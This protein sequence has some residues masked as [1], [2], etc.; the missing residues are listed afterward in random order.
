M[1]RENFG[2]FIGYRNANTST[3]PQKNQLSIKL[4]L[5]FKQLFDQGYSCRGLFLGNSGG[6][7]L[8]SQWNAE[9]YVAAVKCSWGVLVVCWS[10][11][12]ASKA[13]LLPSALGAARPLQHGELDGCVLRVLHETSLGVTGIVTVPPLGLR[14]DRRKAIGRC[15]LRRLN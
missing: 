2:A 4:Q 11:G 15:G 6:T 13:R 12:E 10:G 8:E 5:Q 1:A 3:K 7:I 14:W 9:L